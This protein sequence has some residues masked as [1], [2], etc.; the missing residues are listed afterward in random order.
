MFVAQCT[1]VLFSESEEEMV[2]AKKRKHTLKVKPN[3]WMPDVNAMLVYYT[4]ISEEH[5]DA[6]VISFDFTPYHELPGPEIANWYCMDMLSK[7]EMSKWLNIHLC[8]SM[9]CRSYFHHLQTDGI[10]YDIP[11]HSSSL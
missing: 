5:I 6:D 7:E 3:I 8:T 9:C 2:P 11:L 4:N 1:E 10:V